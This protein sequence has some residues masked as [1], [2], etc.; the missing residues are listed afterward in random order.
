MSKDIVRSELS[1]GIQAREPVCLNRLS[2][3][4]R[5]PALLKMMQE[6]A[7]WFHEYQTRSS[8]LLNLEQEGRL[9]KGA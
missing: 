5:P 8:L 6:Q 4:Q 3:S 2:A 1:S 9:S 7:R